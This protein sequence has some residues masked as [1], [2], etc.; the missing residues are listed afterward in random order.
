[1][2]FTVEEFLNR[3]PLPAD[4]KWK[5]GVWDIEAFKKKM[6]RSFFSHRAAQIIKLFTTKMNFILSFAVQRIDS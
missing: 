6:F 4:E 3:L 5:D 2:K 1:M